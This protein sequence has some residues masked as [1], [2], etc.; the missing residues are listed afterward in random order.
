[1]EDWENMLQDKYKFSIFLHSISI[2]HYI[3]FETFLRTSE[4]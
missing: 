1:M 4:I 3:F 2:A